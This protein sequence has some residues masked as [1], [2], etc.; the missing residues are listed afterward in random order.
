MWQGRRYQIGD[1]V[2]E[3]RLA[4]ALREL[5]SQFRRTTLLDYGCGYGIRASKI[6]E[7]LSPRTVDISLFDVNLDLLREAIQETGGRPW[8]ES[9]RPFDIILCCSVLEIMTNEEVGTT[10]RMF[11]SMMHSQSLLIVL[12]FNWHIL[13]AGTVGWF[14]RSLRHRSTFASA[15]GTHAA[16]R[17][18]R[19]YDS[20]SVLMRHFRDADLQAVRVIR[21]PYLKSLYAPVP[22]SATSF[23]WFFLR[24]V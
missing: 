5:G 15:S 3:R 12:Y 13:A 17:F 16:L 22:L 6:A 24:A 4:S 10:L 14:L 18:P 1:T 8:D 20:L 19:N 11:R 23:N 7:Y 2:T 21:G 9:P